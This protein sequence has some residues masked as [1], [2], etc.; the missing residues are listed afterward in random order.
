MFLL[1]CVKCGTEYS[2]QEVEYTCPKCGYEGIL[3]VIFNYDKLKS[4]YGKEPSDFIDRDKISL[5]RY[6]KLLPI[7]QELNE[8]EGWVGWTPL[9]EAP[10]LRKYL[11][12]QE[13]FIKDD[14]RNPTASLKDRASA[15]GVMKAK[16]RGVKTACCAST[17]NAASSFAYFCA[18][19]GIKPY[20]FVP[21]TAPRAKIAQLLVYGAKVLAVKDTYDRAYELAIEASE[22]WNW[23]NRNCAFNPYLV[24]GKKTMALEVLEQLGFDNP[25]DYIVISIGDGCICSSVGKA[26][27]DF[28]NLGFIKKK[29]RIVG[30]QAEG[31]AP[32]Y[33]AYR[34]GKTEIEEVVPKTLA[35]SIAVGKP[36]NRYKAMKYLKYTDGIVEAVSDAEILEAIKLLARYS[37]VFAEPAGATPFAGYLKLLEKGEIKPSDRVAVVVTG[38]GLK[39]VDAAIKA[40]GNPVEVAPNIEDVSKVI[41][42]E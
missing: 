33:K 27:L 38:N 6:K 11:G 22:K 8:P 20:I 23:Y 34:E 1:K 19:L 15:V 28:Y 29:P 40:T 31:C 39:D 35:D 16:E 7:K 18:L 24:E 5:W 37:G 32:L 12:V 26:I 9:Y 30:V 13:L 42:N 3:D 2:P 25:P 10:R 36:R 4:I 17:G 14:G 21:R 41:E